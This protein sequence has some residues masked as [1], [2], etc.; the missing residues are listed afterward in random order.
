MNAQMKAKLQKKMAIS[1]ATCEYGARPDSLNTH[2]HVIGCPEAQR[3]G[4]A[5]VAPQFYASRLK[6]ASINL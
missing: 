3:T 4:Q 2:P 1:T 5:T 6:V